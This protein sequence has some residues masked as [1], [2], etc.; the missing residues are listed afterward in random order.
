MAYKPVTDHSR[1]REDNKA[2]DYKL[3]TKLKNGQEV[4]ISSQILQYSNQYSIYNF[5][6]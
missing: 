6:Y 1:I 4:R 2:I 5:S 3:I